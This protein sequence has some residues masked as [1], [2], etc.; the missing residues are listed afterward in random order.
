MFRVVTAYR[1][2]EKFPFNF[3]MVDSDDAPE[4]THRKN[5]VIGG[6]WIRLVV[7]CIL[8]NSAGYLLALLAVSARGPSSE[9]G[10]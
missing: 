1:C 2:C 9:Q 7:N 10:H 8:T 6:S 4:T 3:H 5:V